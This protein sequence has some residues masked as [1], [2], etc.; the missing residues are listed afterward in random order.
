MGLKSIAQWV[1]QHPGASVLALGATAGALPFSW[2]A[3]VGV[4]TV[5]GPY[6]VPA[7]GLAMVSL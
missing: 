3:L 4:A 2:P 7:A 6:L 1:K 5:L